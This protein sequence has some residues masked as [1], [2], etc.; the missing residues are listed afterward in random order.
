MNGLRDRWT[1][2]L[3]GFLALALAVGVLTAVGLAL[4]S[5]ARAPER[6][7]ERFAAAPVVV[8]GA[9]ALRVETPGGTRQ[10]PPGGAPRPVPAALARALAELGPVVEDRSVAVRAG[11]AGALV[12]RPWPTAAFASCRLTAGRA[13]QRDGEVVVTGTRARPGDRLRT[14]RGD[15]RVV[16]TGA[17]TAGCARS[18]FL[19]AGHTAR[20]AP[21]V[22]HLVVDAPPAAVRAA[23][24]EH[25]AGAAARVLT[26]GD[27][28]EADPGTARE[29][30]AV[31]ALVALLGT[32]GG[33][34]GFVSVSV[35]ASTFAYSV[36]RRRREFGLLRAAGATPGQ[37]RRAVYAEGL[38]VGAVASAVG[39]ALGGT[40][41][42]PL[43]RWLVERQVAP[44]WFRI[45][46]D[47]WP[48]HA[49]FWTGLVV[50]LAGVAAASWRAGRARPAEALGE[51]PADRGALTGGRALWGGGL[52]L[53][54][55]GLLGYTL[56]V[57]P[58]ELL[59]RKTYTSRPMLLITAVALL[60]PVLVGTAARV[61]T[62]LPARL[63]GAGGL[64]VRAG[65]TGAA[66]R[67]A[68]VAAPA[69]VTVALTGSLLG[70][71]ATLDA[72]RG[73][74]IAR[75]TR[76]D[77]VVTGVDRAAVAALRAV[78]GALV[79]PSAPTETHVLEEGTA[80]VRS[81]A[82]AVDPAVFAAVSA[83]PVA[84]GDLRDLDDRSIVV[85]EEGE[86]RRVG[87]RIT[88]WRADGSPVR[89]RIAAV[90]RTGTGSHGAYVTPANAPG[91]EVD[92]VE[93]RTAPGARA[94]RVDAGVR[95][96]AGDA[97]VR[98]GREY[99]RDLAPRS[100]GTT[101]TGFLLVLGIALVYAGLALANSTLTAAADRLP[102]L[103]ALHRAGAGRGQVLR[104][105]AL[106]AAALVVTGA[107]L[108]ALVAGVQ[109]GGLAAALALLGAPVTVVVPWAGLAAVTGGGLVVAVGTVLAATVRASLSAPP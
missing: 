6:Q 30:A 99:A 32:A 35:V 101:R 45:G 90:L 48:Y 42:P 103:R 38:C 75:A 28:R 83:P 92:R 80:L 68:A 105:V 57:E 51:A 73:A 64:L 20:L 54:A 102:E 19:T 82:R 29:R 59:H 77:H 85:D 37:V 3:G 8:A 89:L 44:G 47:R 58:G 104:F 50:A 62:W 39:C 14:D 66:R 26:G 9:A 79:S 60:T 65:A 63:P 40:A 46:P 13:P 91:A 109:L 52:L 21:R 53:T 7:P 97:R 31:T 33:V 4:A 108:G 86:R 56:V 78:P 5:A 72:S 55:L 106:E 2:F 12:A 1:A 84:A 107:V 36:A 49:A 71:T 34:S 15:W 81:E 11:R 76:A 10:G 27:R 87:E 74:E 88:V 69:L 22:D 95:A 98:T 67:G 43:A 70:T 25:P 18:A 16:G 41:A 100:H 93:V 24:A 23:V 61:L 94:D 96:A 17:A